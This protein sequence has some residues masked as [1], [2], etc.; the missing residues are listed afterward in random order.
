MKK[1]LLCLAFALLLISCGKDVVDLYTDDADTTSG[2]VGPFV[3]TANIQLASTS[4]FYP[5]EAGSLKHGIAIA[6]R[7]GDT[8]DN[9]RVGTSDTL[10]VNLNGV[11]QIIGERRT[12]HC[13]GG[14]S[15]QCHYSYHYWVAFQEAPENKPLMI[16][17]ERVTGVSSHTTA[18]FPSRPTILEPVPN[19]LV[20]LSTDTLSISWMPGEVGDETILT[21]SGDCGVD[22]GELKFA[23]PDSS[24]R[25]FAPG[26]F[27][28]SKYFT[29]CVDATE[30]PLILRATRNRN[31]AADPALAPS[32]TLQL[33]VTDEIIVRMNP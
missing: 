21:V 17:L 32:S 10:L 9:L 27:Q 16:S 12:V 13:K 26:T 29:S 28:F 30:M 3:E 8:L 25:L 5:D 20:S 15:L 19:T 7:R 31:A 4:S 1:A 14:L 6:L 23:D 22:S 33:G 18:T 11:P 2:D 24:S